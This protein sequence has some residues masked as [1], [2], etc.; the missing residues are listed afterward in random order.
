MH[1][2]WTREGWSEKDWA[3]IEFISRELLDVSAE[4]DNRIGGGGGGF[5]P[6]ELQAL[7][8]LTSS[9]TARLASIANSYI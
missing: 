1:K 5:T 6:E 7:V 9:L 3:D 8:K 2:Q 4:L